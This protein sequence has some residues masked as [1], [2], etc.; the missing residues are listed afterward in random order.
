VRPNESAIGFRFQSRESHFVEAEGTAVTIKGGDFVVAGSG[1]DDS[2]SRCMR[3]ARSASRRVAAA[4]H[5]H[6]FSLIFI[7]LGHPS[8]NGSC[9]DIRTS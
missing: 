5:F 4:A 2:A 8:A 1:A 6:S 7:H 9:N 3:A